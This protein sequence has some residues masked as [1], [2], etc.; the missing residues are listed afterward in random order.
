M[1][2]ETTLIKIDRETDSR[3]ETL[4][5]HESRSKVDEIRFLIRERAKKLEV[6]FK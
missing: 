5:K 3:L 2:K 1:I 4:A 6:K